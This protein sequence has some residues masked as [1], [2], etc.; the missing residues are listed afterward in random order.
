[1]TTTNLPAI[2]TADDQAL[3]DATAKEV[4]KIFESVAT[5]MVTDDTSMAKA[6]DMVA[7]VK[8]GLKAIELKRVERTSPLNAD[9]NQIN[10]LF[11]PIKKKGLAAVDVLTRQMKDHLKEMDRQKRKAEMDR[12]RLE[13]EQRAKEKA[14][15]EEL[16]ALGDDEAK[17]QLAINGL[18]E[19][20][21]TR[22]DPPIKRAVVH[23][24]I[25]R[26]SLVPGPVTIRVINIKQVPAKYLE[27]NETAV[28]AAFH[29]GSRN[30]AGL[31]VKQEQTLR[32][33]G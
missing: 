30:F 32:V 9:L 27:V 18:R 15:L 25:G 6:T 17:R 16:T 19:K 28:R 13:A 12:Q 10:G 31:E 8:R 20:E 14:D 4:D 33:S 23:G 11:N 2:I 1:M 24:S 7:L 22:G 21:A 5:F 26:S 29:S 3:L